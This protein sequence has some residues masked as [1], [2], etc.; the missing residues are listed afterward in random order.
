MSERILPILGDLIAFDTT[1]RNSNLELIEYIGAWLD[2]RGVAPEL[3]YDDDRRKANLFANLGPAGRPGVVLSGHTDVVPVDEQEWSSDPF[4]AEVREDR[5]YG[6]G[7]A[8]MKG[9]V[10]ACLAM[11]DEILQ[12]DLA[13]PVHF[14]FS[15]D[16]E[17]GCLGIRRLLEQLLR[18][19]LRPLACIVGEPTGMQM[20]RAHKGMLAKRCHVHGSPCHSSLPE[21]GV[22]AVDYAAEL[23]TRIRAMAERRRREGPFDPA[24]DP[25]TTTLHT[26]LIHGGTAINIVPE[27]CWFDFEIRNLPN[28]DPRALFSELEGY[29]QGELLR[30]MRAVSDRSRI[31]WETLTEFPGLDTD[32]QAPVATLVRRLL[33]ADEPSGKVSYGTEAGIF[34]ESGIPAVICGPGHIE[35]AHRAD[36]HVALEQLERCETL[37]SSLIDGL[38]DPSLERLL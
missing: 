29:A 3:T 22:N 20:V 26:G 38:R 4:R 8:D 1:S 17:V 33:G 14:S 24:F 35:Q 19:P 11:T 15:Y 12:A 25:P 31:E 36:E 28:D 32:E 2:R 5:L 6:R 7:S 37:I 21:Q 23:V 9:F 16:E 30:S 34:A 10:A 27:N 18:R 13:I